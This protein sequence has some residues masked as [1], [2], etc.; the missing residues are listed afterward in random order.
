MN[1]PRVSKPAT[2][3]PLPAIIVLPPVYRKTIQNPWWIASR[4]TWIA[5]IFANLPRRRWRAA[6]CS[7]MTFAPCVHKYATPAVMN[8]PNTRLIIVSNVRRPAV[9]VPRNVATWRI[10][11]ITGV[12]SKASFPFF[13]LLG[14][15]E[16]FNCRH[17]GESRNPVKSITWTPVFA[18]VT[19]ESAFPL[20]FV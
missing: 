10:D 6:A 3:V 20:G 1:T 7:P 14:S 4:S 11:S 13:D 15:D 16:Q 18:G 9:A 12:E 8:V 19:N 17:S 2:T 5:P